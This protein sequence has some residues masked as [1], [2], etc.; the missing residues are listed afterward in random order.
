MKKNDGMESYE[1]E[2]EFIPTCRKCGAVLNS[3]NWHD[4][5]KLVS[6]YICINCRCEYAKKRYLENKE[7]IKAL[8]KKERGKLNNDVINGY[9]GKCACCGET[10][11][12]YL[13][14]DHKDGGGNKQKREIGVRNSTGLYRWLIQNNYPEG[15]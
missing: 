10:R 1:N 7:R 14:I 3:K 6:N 4:S 9:G 8:D 15:F 2:L 13:S 12:E 5:D 11:K